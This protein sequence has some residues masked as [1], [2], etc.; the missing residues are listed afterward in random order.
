MFCG[1]SILNLLDKIFDSKKY[2]KPLLNPLALLILMSSG[3]SSD[4]NSTQKQKL[5]KEQP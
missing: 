1:P 3:E 2:S 5:F 4:S